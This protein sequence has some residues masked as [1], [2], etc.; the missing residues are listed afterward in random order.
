MRHGARTERRRWLL[1]Q[2]WE[3]P[4]A[5]FH[6]DFYAGTMFW[7]RREV[8]EPLRRLHL[9]QSDFP[10]EQMQRDGELQHAIERLFGNLPNMIGKHM[11]DAVP[12]CLSAGSV[13]PRPLAGSVRSS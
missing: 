9:L 11:E 3:I 6:L 10:E 13:D 5:N 8:L 4:E 1:R 2:N 7:A 12:A